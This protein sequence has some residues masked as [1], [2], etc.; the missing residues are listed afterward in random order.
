VVQACKLAE[1]HQ[2]IE[3]LPQGYQTEIGEHGVGLSGGQKQ[4]IAIARALLKRPKVLIFDEATSNLDQHTA[5]QFAKTV[6]MLK[7]QATM[8]FITHHLP[9]QLQIERVVTLKSGQIANAVR[10]GQIATDAA[11]A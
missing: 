11:K 5:E 10:A 1:I 7:G 6:N 2:T 8:L 3:E 9:E 4:R